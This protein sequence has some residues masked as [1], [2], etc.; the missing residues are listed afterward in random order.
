MVTVCAV[1]GELYQQIVDNLCSKL[2]VQ[3]STFSVFSLDTL[4]TGRIN[5]IDKASQYP[6]V[7][8]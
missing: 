4:S 3:P 1:E 8:M 5:Q 2:S 7:N 6:I